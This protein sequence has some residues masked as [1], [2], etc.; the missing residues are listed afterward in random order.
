MRKCRLLHLCSLQCRSIGGMPDARRRRS[1]GIDLAA[2]IKIGSGAILARLLR[3]QGGRRG[4]APSR[5]SSPATARS[6]AASFCG[7]VRQA[8]YRAIFSGDLGDPAASSAR[9]ADLGF[10]SGFSGD[11]GRSSGNK[12][13]DIGSISGEGEGRSTAAAGAAVAATPA[14]KEGIRLR[15]L[16]LEEGSG[17]LGRR[18]AA[19]CRGKIGLPDFGHQRRIGFISSG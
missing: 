18:A 5:A 12:R 2:G 7:G 13:S 19:C 17:F 14:V 16:H 9:S 15:F 10:F 4:A 3:W 8:R 6:G 11:S 1:G